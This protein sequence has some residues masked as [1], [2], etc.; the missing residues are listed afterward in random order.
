MDD[1]YKL[2]PPSKS[3][4]ENS[5]DDLVKIL[6]SFPTNV[7]DEIC[8]KAKMLRERLYKVQLSDTFDID[9]KADLFLNDFPDDANLHNSD[10]N[11]ICLPHNKSLDYSKEIGITSRE[12]ISSDEGEIVE[13]IKE[14][15]SELEA[16]YFENQQEA[17]DEFVKPNFPIERLP[18]NAFCRE[19]LLKHAECCLKG[20]LLEHS[21]NNK[22]LQVSNQNSIP[23][24]TIESDD[25]SHET[26]N[27]DED[28]TD[29]VPEHS[30][31]ESDLPN[32][33][34]QRVLDNSK[35][36]KKIRNDQI[37]S[38][39]EETL[40]NIQDVYAMKEETVQ[41]SSHRNSELQIST[42]IPL[43]ST[44]S[45]DN[46]LEMRNAIDDEVETLEILQEDTSALQA[47]LL[48]NPKGAFVESA[49]PKRRSTTKACQLKK[50][51][52]VK[53]YSQMMFTS[54]SIEMGGEISLGTNW[55]TLFLIQIA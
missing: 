20:S 13:N 55:D 50:D 18:K 45:A 17:F 5:Y 24:P 34:E 31:N 44:K 15:V 33:N 48:E 9:A 51:A 36:S 43:S 11:E 16:L 10:E 27:S 28:M 29:S 12:E 1:S 42:E 37:D 52:M 40:E 30:G 38:Y 4:D 8:S 53:E 22:D 25:N 23:L 19:W 6:S 39:E 54:A 2:N 35:E 3:M 41:N 21:D 7:I 47:L 49:K 14:D 26:K 46:S 32:L